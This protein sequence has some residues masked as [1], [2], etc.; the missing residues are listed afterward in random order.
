MFHVGAIIELIEND[1]LMNEQEEEE[2][3]QILSIGQC[4]EQG[5]GALPSTENQKIKIK[6]AR[7][8]HF[9]H[10]KSIDGDEFAQ[11]TLQCGYFF[12]NRMAAWEAIKPAPPVIK[13]FFGSYGIS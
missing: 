10:D 4:I 13:I 2:Q 6:R 3:Q 5:G 1:D 8:L 12:A 9:A 7:F 11:R